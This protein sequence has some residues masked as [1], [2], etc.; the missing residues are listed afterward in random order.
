MQ[1]IS[2]NKEQQ[3]LCC[4][5]N[6]NNDPNVLNVNDEVD[7]FIETQSEDLNVYVNIKQIQY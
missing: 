3:A 2:E 6:T 7:Y 5:A 1:I 4:L